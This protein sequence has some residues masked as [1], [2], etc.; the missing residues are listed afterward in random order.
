MKQV[1]D[2][3]KE[4]LERE[5]KTIHQYSQYLAYA[6]EGFK[7]LEYFS[8]GSTTPATVILEVDSNTNTAQL[9]VDFV[10]Y[11]VIGMKHG[12]SVVTLG[13]K[14]NL[15]L[16]LGY[17]DCGMPVANAS[18]CC[19]NGTLDSVASDYLATGYGYMFTGWGWGGSYK[20]FGFGGGYSVNYFRVDIANRRI[21]LDGAVGTGEI[22]MEYLTNK[23]RESSYV[24]PYCE[25]ALKAYIDW[26]AK[27]NRRNETISARQMAEMQWQT[28][29]DLAK[30]QI[31]AWTPH[32]FIK[33][34]RRT[35]TETVKL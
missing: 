25:N 8:T 17:N 26:Q 35:N 31:Q 33:R 2:I 1:K 9:P 15:L 20:L 5:G 21:I 10:D 19:C 4:K 3:V 6:V 30:R 13:S 11:L 22:V 16:Q 7:K 34:M 14:D 12:N 28:E 24:H 29:A 32:D 23:A 18:E 27:L